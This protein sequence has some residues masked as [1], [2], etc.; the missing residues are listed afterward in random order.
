MDRNE[1]SSFGSN[2]IGPNVLALKQC[3]CE[4]Y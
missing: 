1:T 4:I 2:E 3:V